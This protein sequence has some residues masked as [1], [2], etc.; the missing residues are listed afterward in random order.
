MVSENFLSETFPKSK[1]KKL[2][3]DFGDVEIVF[4]NE[5]FFSA[6]SSTR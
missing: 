1:K 6:V 3:T 4:A 2:G 5:F